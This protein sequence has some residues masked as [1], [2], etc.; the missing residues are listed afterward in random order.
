MQSQRRPATGSASLFLGTTSI[1]III[2]H[3]F[4]QHKINCPYLCSRQFKQIC[5]LSSGKSLHINGCRTNVSSQTVPHKR[6][7]DRKVAC[8]EYSPGSWNNE[9]STV[10]RPK[11]SDGVM[12]FVCT[13]LQLELRR[14]V[15]NTHYLWLTNHSIPFWNWN[16][17]FSH[18]SW[19]ACL[20]LV[21]FSDGSVR[22][23]R[24]RLC[25]P[26]FEIN[27]IWI[28]YLIHLY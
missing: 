7:S 1:I 19:T 10:S 13:G 16:G 26:L 6:I 18:Q 11:G 8:A 20:L 9:T 15:T 24:K 5:L 22:L 25:D 21:F 12:V 14:K 2:M 28:E 17:C 27:N 23:N 3:L 4:L